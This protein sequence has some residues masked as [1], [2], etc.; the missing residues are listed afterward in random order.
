MTDYIADTHAL[1]WY[2]ENSSRLG[3]QA[4]AAFDACDRGEICIYVP[5]ICLVEVVY[6][7]EKGR[8]SPDM[9]SMLDKELK[10]GESGL[11]LVD[12]NA[13]VADQTAN[14][15]REDIPDLPD[16]VIAATALALN[17]PLIS[18]D[19]K[20]VLSGLETVW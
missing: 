14:V 4:R 5:T 17:L 3:S 16:R 8:V 12:L 9:K 20:I 7:M 6:L 13:D 18:R 10:S 15:L 19:R 1:I 2:L 11:V